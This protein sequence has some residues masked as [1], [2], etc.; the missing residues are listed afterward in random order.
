MKNTLTR[1]DIENSKE[2]INKEEKFDNKNQEIIN[3]EKI[4]NIKIIKTSQNTEVEQ[5]KKKKIIK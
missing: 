2:I 3:N 1:E 4:E 5:P